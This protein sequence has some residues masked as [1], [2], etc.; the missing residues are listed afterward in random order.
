MCRE[1]QIRGGVLKGA[2][3]LLNVDNILQGELKEFRDEVFCL[4]EGKPPAPP[5]SMLKRGT[6]KSMPMRQK[7][8]KFEPG[9][10][11]APN[12]EMGGE[13]G[14]L[15]ST[16]R[17]LLRRRLK[18][19]VRFFLQNIV[20]LPTNTFPLLVFSHVP[21]SPCSAPA[22]FFGTPYAVPFT[23]RPGPFLR[24]GKATAGENAQ[25]RGRSHSQVLPLCAAGTS[26]RT[27]HG[28][29]EN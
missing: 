7:F 4:R 17:R 29:W 16:Y 26:R 25:G 27:P 22:S 23:P 15:W 21:P 8:C 18:T 6:R 3:D 12:I 5:I 24:K 20:D 28:R 14:A 1:G 13:G 19:S 11:L 10:G 2:L 9:L